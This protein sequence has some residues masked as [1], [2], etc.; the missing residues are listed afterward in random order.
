MK[1]NPNDIKSAAYRHRTKQIGENGDKKKRHC[2]ICE[3]AFGPKD[4]LILRMMRIDGVFQEY[5]YHSACYF[6][7]SN[8]PDQVERNVQL[9]GY[10]DLEPR[11][12]DEILDDMLFRRRE[13][14]I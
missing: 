11:I 2:N 6:S 1:R 7:I 5:S 14:E 13:R 4:V 10:N 8:F 3:Q 9:E 12:K